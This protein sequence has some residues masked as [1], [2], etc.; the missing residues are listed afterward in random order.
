MSEVWTWLLLRALVLLC[1]SNF[2]KYVQYNSLKMSAVP[3]TSSQSDTSLIR[4]R[5]SNQ[6]LNY[7]PLVGNVSHQIMGAKLPSIRQILQ[8]F[9]YNM[10]YVHLNA[11]QSATLTLDAIIIFWQQARIPT[12]RMDHCVES[13]LRIYDKWKNIQKVVPSKRTPRILENEKAFVDSLDDLFDIASAT[14][15]TTMRNEEDK[16]FLLMQREKGRPGCMAGVDTRLAAREKR[17]QE[18]RLIE[19][20]RKRK[21]EEELQQ[22]LVEYGDAEA[23]ADEGE[24][25]AEG[26]V[27]EFTHNARS[28]KKRRINW[29]TP[30]LTGAFDNGKVTDTHAMHIL[31]ATIDALNSALNLQI[32]VDQLVISRTTI[33]EQRRENRKE[34]AKKT[35]ADFIENVI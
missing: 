28:S 4:T 20:A 1:A 30:R 21:H 27:R 13:L 2:V 10:H 24:Q 26:T 17:S 7:I 5:K 31:A 34:K 15:L 22:S 16:K 19:E 6:S 29:I 11:K 35:K 14:A 23:D 25:S 9:F 33:H 3:S 8:T 18:R 12:R 32:P